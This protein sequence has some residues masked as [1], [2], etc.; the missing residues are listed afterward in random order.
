V[1]VPWVRLRS[2]TSD[3]EVLSDRSTRGPADS[4]LVGPVGAALELVL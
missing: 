3:R 2:A 1:R 4:W